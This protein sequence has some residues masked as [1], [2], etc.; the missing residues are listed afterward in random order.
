MW[1]SFLADMAQEWADSC[2]W[3]HGQPA[4][5]SLP[6][7]PVGQ[8]LYYVGGGSMDIESGIQ[9][10]YDEKK[11]YKYDTGVCLNVCGHYTQV[12]YC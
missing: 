11:D 6:Y 5:S 4:R 3:E 12:R 8:N 10:W 9:A 7:D 2:V 1:N